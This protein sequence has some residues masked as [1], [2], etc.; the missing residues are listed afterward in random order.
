MSQSPMV[1][2]RAN[3]TTGIKGKLLLLACVAGAEL[4]VA[5]AGELPVTGAGLL[6]GAGVGVEASGAV[7]V[8]PLPLVVGLVAVDEPAGA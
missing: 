4:S 5:G 8:V 7:S 2:R 1:S 3:P 6:L